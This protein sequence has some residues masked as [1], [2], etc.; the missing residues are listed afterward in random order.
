MVQLSNRCSS[1]GSYVC[2][3]GAVACYIVGWH[4]TGWKFLSGS[5][6]CTDY[7]IGAHCAA[8]HDPLLTATRAATSPSEAAKGSAETMGTA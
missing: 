6:T 3:G 2:A 7:V 4:T 8:P 1:V 5:A